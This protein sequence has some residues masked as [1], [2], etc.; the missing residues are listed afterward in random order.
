MNK[1]DLLGWYDD[2]LFMSHNVIVEHDA[3]WGNAVT[4]FERS[5]QCSDLETSVAS[6]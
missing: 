3:V 2:S 5:F 6:Y 1:P 4:G